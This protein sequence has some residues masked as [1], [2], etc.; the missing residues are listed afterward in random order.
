MR[1][2]CSFVGNS[3]AVVRTA[4]HN[5]VTCKPGGAVAKKFPI[6]LIT[7]LLPQLRAP[8]LAFAGGS[9]TVNESGNAVSLSNDYLERTLQVT[10]GVVTTTQLWKKISH[11]LY[12][13]SGDEFELR[14]NFQDTSAERESL[15]ALT[16]R[17][18][19]IVDRKVE[20]LEGGGRRVLFHLASCHPL[21][22]YAGVEVAIVYE[23]NPEDYYTRQ[24][25]ELKPTGK[26]SCF[27]DSVWVHKN[28]WGLA[29]F[30]HGGFGQALRV[31]VI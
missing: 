14:L 22:E 18:F 10:D 16:S 20:A 7:V 29:T 27:T 6:I 25:I 13:L 3:S 26:G 2:V 8:H 31:S 24:W 28:K 4:R 12:S 21:S 17:N 23:L 30:S 9:V 5:R 19:A 15:L 11:R 1:P